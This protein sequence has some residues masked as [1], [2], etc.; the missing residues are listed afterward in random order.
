[1]FLADIP[2]TASNPSAGEEAAIPSVPALFWGGPCSTTCYPAKFNRILPVVLPGPY[3]D[4]EY[5]GFDYFDITASTNPNTHPPSLPV[6][7]SAGVQCYSGVK[8]SVVQTVI[9]GVGVYVLCL[10]FTP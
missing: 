8:Q 5:T 1:M 3:T 2:T 6:I 4:Y 10:S 9:H 7:N